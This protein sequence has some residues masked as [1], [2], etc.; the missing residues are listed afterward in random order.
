MCPFPLDLLVNAVEAATFVLFLCLTCFWDHAI[1]RYWFDALTSPKEGS[2]SLPA[3]T[4]WQ[5]YKHPMVTVGRKFTHTSFYYL[6]DCAIS[7]AHSNHDNQPRK[8]KILPF[9]SHFTRKRVFKIHYHCYVTPFLIT[10]AQHRTHTQKGIIFTT[11]SMYK[12]STA[13]RKQPPL[14][15][16]QKHPN[17]I[18]YQS[19]FTYKTNRKN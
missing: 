14:G 16:L 15:C 9:S 10:V 5:F 2:C 18:N 17:G 19:V 1:S 13:S 3:I 12:E 7:I 6:Q 4:C 11:C 8:K